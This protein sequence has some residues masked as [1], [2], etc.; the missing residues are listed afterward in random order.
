MYFTSVQWLNV[1]KYIYFYFVHF[2]VPIPSKSIFIFCNFR[3]LLH[4]ILEANIAFFTT[5]IW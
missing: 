1:I 4:Y 2:E 5:F 3:F